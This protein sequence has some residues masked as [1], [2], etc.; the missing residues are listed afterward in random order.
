M[1][2]KVV[3][4]SLVVALIG[5]LCIINSHY[6]VWSIGRLYGD[7]I[8]NF[9]CACILPTLFIAIYLCIGMFCLHESST[10]TEKIKKKGRGHFLRLEAKLNLTLKQIFACDIVCC[11]VAIVLVSYFENKFLACDAYG[12]CLYRRGNLYSGSLLSSENLVALYTKDGKTIVYE[13]GVIGDVAI[14]DD[15]EV[16]GDLFPICGG[17]DES[18]VMICPGGPYFCF[19]KKVDVDLK[20]KGR[21]YNY[22]E[23]DRKVYYQY[24]RCEVTYLVSIYNSEGIYVDD[25]EEKYRFY[26][27]PDQKDIDGHKYF[28]SING[29]DF[30]S[31]WDFEQKMGEMVHE[32]L[33]Y[34]VS[35]MN[36]ENTP[37][38]KNEH[39][40]EVKPQTTPQTTTSQAKPKP[41][42]SQPEP[43]PVPMQV[44]KK[45]WSCL[46]GGQC[47]ACYGSGVIHYPTGQQFCPVCGG[48]GR[49][50]I[51]AGRGGEYVVEY[52]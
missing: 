23:Y 4:F 38:S 24:E 9:I 31:S 30:E 44:F 26:Y 40:H 2:R 32:D 1:N 16:R 19:R 8:F 51:C 33:E 47:S 39:V 18:C 15:L 11:I 52:H 42:V 27:Y 49:C 22:D 21:D 34:Y 45:C 3:I 46:G 14:H 48:T 29:E 35:H 12:N 41:A 36:D 25:F 13:V 43:K 10:W 7:D 50:N 17:Y 5:F 20:H 28:Y 37:S 6:L